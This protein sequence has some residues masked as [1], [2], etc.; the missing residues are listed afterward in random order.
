MMKYIK[1]ISMLFVLALCGLFFA[2]VLSVIEER[3]YGKPRNPKH[4]FIIKGISSTRA[5][6]QVQPM[7]V[8]QFFL[9]AEDRTIPP[10]L[11]R[12]GTLICRDKQLLTMEEPGLK[13]YTVFLICEGGLKF[14][15]GGIL[16]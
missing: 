14:S 8:P 5:R 3:M 15:I 4:V 11:R 16:F 1:L 2:V 10:T 12:G 7:I 9:E 6:L 13:V